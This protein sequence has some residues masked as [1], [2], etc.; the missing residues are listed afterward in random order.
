MSD[1]NDR[2]AVEFIRIKQ[3][4]AQFMSSDKRLAMNSGLT[5]MAFY[6]FCLD[7]GYS[8]EQSKK[9]TLDSGLFS[10][11]AK[12]MHKEITPKEAQQ[13]FTG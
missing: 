11:F 10:T 9:I 8:P 13:C 4:D 6:Q 12:F 3:P 2:T 5:A 7:E 1:L